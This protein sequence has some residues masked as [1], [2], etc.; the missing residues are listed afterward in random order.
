MEESYNWHPAFISLD[1]EAVRQETE[2]LYV[3]VESC[4]LATPTTGESTTG[5][6]GEQTE[7]GT[8]SRPAASL[9]NFG[10]VVDLDHSGTHVLSSSAEPV[11][12][13]CG[14][15]P[16][17]QPHD[18]LSLVRCYACGQVSSSLRMQ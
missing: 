10:A 4:R 12:D 13:V 8:E 14:C 7:T 1:E 17:P 2:W 9:A 18:I 5:E 6:R 3:D 15:S 16:A 11:D